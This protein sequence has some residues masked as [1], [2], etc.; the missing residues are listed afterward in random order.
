M[1]SRKKRALDLSLRDRLDG[2]TIGR[3]D[4]LDLGGGR[5]RVAATLESPEH[6]NGLL[7]YFWADEKVR[8]G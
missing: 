8:V 3:L 1:L 2:L 6:P 4:L 5:R 7:R